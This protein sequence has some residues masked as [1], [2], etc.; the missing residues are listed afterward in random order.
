MKTFSKLAAALLCTSAAVPTW[1]Q[2]AS[3]PVAASNEDA[4]AEIVVTGMR[5]SLQS[6]AQ[7]K[8]NTN[9]ILDT[10]SAEDIGKLP[11][12]NVAATLSRVPGVQAYRFGGESASPVG[13]GSGLTI[14]GLSGQT[15][16]QVDG[17]AFITAGGREFNVEGASP[18]MVAGIDVYKNPSAEHIE[19]G[20]GG[21]VDIRTRRPLDFI[22]TVV[23]G[24][25]GGRY[26]DLGKK[27]QP[28]LFVLGSTKWHVGD[29][30]M[31]LL[32]AGSFSRSFNRG[33]NNPAGGGTSIRRAIRGDSAEYATNVGSGLNL[34]P[35][36]AGR[37]DVVYLAD[38]ANP[39]AFSA[40]D[41]ANLVSTV[42]EGHNVF[43][44]DYLRTRKGLAG[45]FQYKPTPDLEFYVD[46]N[47]TYYQYHQNYRFLNIANSR[48]V[49]NLTTVPFALDEVLANR[50]INGGTDELLS[51]TRLA[52]GTF[53]GSGASTIGG[54]ERSNYI[55][56]LVAGG[57]KWR[58]TDQFDV[59]FDYSY[60]KADRSTDN[61]SLTIAGR[62]GLG[63]NVSRDLTTRPAQF[64]ITGPSLSD[65]N[66]WVF[67]NYA[68]GTNQAWDDNSGA[69][70]LDL[71]YRPRDSFIKAVKVGARYSVLES[72]YS[73]HSFSRNLT[74]DGAGLKPDQSNGIPI[75]SFSDLFETSP[76]NF[77]NGA[78]GY[79]GGYLVY[80]PSA[81]LGDTVR[82][83]FPAAGILPE[84]SL[85]ENLLNRRYIR[86]RTYAAYVASDFALLDDR[87][88]GNIGV[89]AVRAEGFARAM[90]NSQASPTAPVIIIPNETSS[91]RWDVL[92]SANLSWRITRD[93]ILRLG[94]G[95]GISRASTDALNPAISV[96]TANGLGSK[97]NTSLGPQKA[98]N[99]D[100]SLEHYFSPVNYAAV[101][102]FYKDV[103]GFF[104][105]ISQCETVATYPAYTG[106]TA[107]GCTGGQYYITQTVN[108]QNGW[109]KG[110][111][112]S[113]QTFFDYDFVPKFLHHFGAS[114]SFTY[115]DT[116]N[117][118]LLNGVVVNTPQPF[119][120]K[121]N[122]T[123]S[124]FYEDKLLTAR[125][126]YTYR[127][128]S[129]LFGASANP[130]DGRAIRAFGL[131]DAS[132]SFKVLPQLTLSLNAENLTNAAADRFVGEPGL[133]T[134]IE[135][136]H[137]YNGRN[138]SAALHF[139]F[140]H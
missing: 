33:D 35:A 23:S 122:W 30:E 78:M 40:A 1:A 19:G 139:R 61:R 135:R 44:E 86:E 138:F 49:Q 24:S 115:V 129:I 106:T 77:M 101:A 104:S 124:G 123:A 137:F 88:Q 76:S 97:G 43:Q 2:D 46:G 125:L 34:N 9:E 20:I 68:N 96:N 17:R 116:K 121:Y 75:S 48:Y 103:K 41:R 42:T 31:G 87:I 131:L 54:D 12:N 39:L 85:A 110:F 58:V 133:N 65:P 5:E 13:Q 21:L 130:I 90:V 37:S 67:S 109:A 63:W 89:R 55:S 114:G 73:N 140:G 95:K 32:L 62:A 102:V 91:S 83:R 4:A 92:P 94:Y 132:L 22:G 64:G 72:R 84:N 50:N 14:R 105:G 26:N 71:R 27:V 93:T 38:V 98:D 60:V 16:S 81:L 11:D 47:Y 119:T 134:G 18:G 107:N 82:A 118:L 128:E 56:F 69:A 36:Y 51:G 45:S 3:Q 25:V 52:T 10:I 80:S 28:E 111:E 99:F 29:G 136:Q 112:I 120:S 8:K 113:G 15:S 126:V 74:T 66:N 53:L 59:H 127:S 57:V 6:S 100:I 117:P 79:S 70:A 108:A 7:R